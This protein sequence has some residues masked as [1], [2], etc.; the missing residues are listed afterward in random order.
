MAPGKKELTVDVAAQVSAGTSAVCSTVS[1]VVETDF[2]M[3]GVVIAIGCKAKVASRTYRQEKTQSRQR[4]ASFCQ[5][6]RTSLKP[7]SLLLSFVKLWCWLRGKEFT[8]N[9]ATPVFAVTSA[10]PL[11]TLLKLTLL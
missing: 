8:A 1:D 7:A 2:I 4:R 3:T 11:V 6:K 5:K 9:D 10:A